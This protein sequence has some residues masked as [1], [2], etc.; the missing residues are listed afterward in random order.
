MKVWSKCV[1][2][3]YSGQ[4]YFFFSE[5]DG[6]TPNPVWNFFQKGGGG[7]GIHF[8]RLRKK[9]QLQNGCQTLYVIYNKKKGGGGHSFPQIKKET[10]ATKWMLV[11]LF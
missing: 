6:F 3:H 7:D 9:L 1:F 8:L 4:F 2:L 10:T 5:V 11:M